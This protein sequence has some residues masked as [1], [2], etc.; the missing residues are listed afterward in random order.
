MTTLWRLS[1]HADFATLAEAA[2]RL[3]A[4][5]EPLGL[6]WSIFEDGA[7]ARLDLM[8]TI[9]PEAEEFRRVS[10]LPDHIKLVSEPIPDE[11]WVRISLEGL[12]PVEAGRDQS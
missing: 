7:L 1:A 4:A 12:K 9:L 6:S 3:D 2:E 5:E 8:C 10:G 11:D